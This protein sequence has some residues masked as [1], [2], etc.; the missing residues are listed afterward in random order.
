MRVESGGNA[1]AVSPKGA[2]GLMQIMPDTWAE[3]R[4]RYRLGADPFDPHDN[5][6]AGAAYLREML[7]RFGTAG[8][9]AA[10]NAGP[11]RFEDYLAGLRPLNGETQRYLA[12]LAHMLPDVGIAISGTNTATSADQHFAGLF[13]ATS[14]ASPPP[15]DA[16]ADHPSAATSNDHN[17]ALAPQPNALFV[18][19]GTASQR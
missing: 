10:Y 6:A 2:M 12:T 13:V 7:D 4:A 11:S 1:L 14:S 17:F 9:L 18:A 8:F 19:V 16:P 5:I 15:S 3:L